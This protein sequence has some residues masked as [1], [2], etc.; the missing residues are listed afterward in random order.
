M[1]T[2][3]KIDQMKDE[4]INNTK[5]LINF[6]SIE[7]KT[8][9]YPYG[10]GVQESLEFCLNLCKSFD[11]KTKN[12]NN[13]VGYAEIGSGDE[14]V[15]ILVHLDVVP[16]GNEKD[17]KYP[18]FK[19]TIKEDKL[20][21]RGSIDDKGPTI[22][23]I[24]A[25]KAINDSNL[26]LN[27]RFRII[28]GL[29]E[30]TDWKSINYYLK[31]EDIPNMAFTPDADFP[32]IKGEKG[33]LNFNLIKKFKESID[34]G[35]VEVLN[36]TGGSRKNMVPDYTKVILKENNKKIKHILD[37]FNNKH[38]IDIK[39][40]KNN[41]K[42]ILS[43]KG[44]SAH[45]ATPEKGTNA[46]SY[47]L[48][49]LNLIDLKI[50]DISNFIRF[51]SNHIGLDTNGKNLNCNISDKKSG[52]LTF[53]VG[54]IELNSNKV[55]IGVNI[56]YPVT[57][58]GKEIKNKL[59][60]ALDKSI[61]NSDKKIK[62]KNVKNVNPIYF[63]DDHPLVKSLMEVY[64]KYTKDNNKAITIGGGTYARS[65][66]NAVAFGPLF[67]NRE[68]LAH[69]VNEY[70]LIKDLILSCKIYSSAIKKLNEV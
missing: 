56:R 64:Q 48:K 31:N 4:I 11:F 10:K 34:D 38:N 53:N 60:K 42:T 67:P 41:S 14:L 16:V 36:I 35:G 20:Y 57:F 24:Y 37:A 69:Q 39:Y 65:I 55:K 46:I 27:K 28:F 66:K 52:E 3:K 50:G 25:M 58:D 44:K 21:G 70:V 13:K 22:S 12:L 45:G 30:E 23:A 40:D 1:D 29:N 51:Y 63:K 9:D 47:L 68:D 6:K 5:K 8:S 33:I 61:Y 26:N 17:W 2:D 62:I 59:K 54:T 43:L 19:A 15:G 49:F 18:P 7:D 32:V